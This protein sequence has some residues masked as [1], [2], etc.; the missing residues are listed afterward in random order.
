[1]TYY[2]DEQSR[3]AIAPQLEAMLIEK[4]RTAPTLGQRIT[5][6]RAFPE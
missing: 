5:Y 4:M 6:Y 3:D 2:I 1:M